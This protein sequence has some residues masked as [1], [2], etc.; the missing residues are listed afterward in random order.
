MNELLDAQ[1][2]SYLPCGTLEPRVHS[3]PT[4]VNVC[5][6]GQWMEGEMDAVQDGSMM[7]MS[8]VLP[9]H[10]PAPPRGCHS[11][12]AVS[13]LFPSVPVQEAPARAPSL[14]A[15]LPASQHISSSLKTAVRLR[16]PP[17]HPPLLPPTPESRFG[18]P[19][20]CLYSLQLMK[21]FIILL[22]VAEKEVRICIFP[23][24]QVVQA[25]PVTQVSPAVAPLLLMHRSGGSP[26]ALQS[27]PPASPDTVGR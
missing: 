26:P 8:Q 22:A 1:G 25:V 20:R 21:I 9:D 16:S 6:V 11:C 19:M 7:G 2:R 14:T 13:Y 17:P 15:T 3:W 27:L 18:V 23:A 24:N 5:G 12:R 4:A 10:T